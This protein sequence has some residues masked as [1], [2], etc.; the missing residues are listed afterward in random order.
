MQTALRGT[1]SIFSPGQ[2]LRRPSPG[3]TFPSPNPSGAA[4]GPSRPSRHCMAAT[5]KQG[6][7]LLDRP[8]V[9]PGMDRVNETK[10]KKPPMYRV[11]LHNDNNNRR[12]YVVKVLMK[13]V[14]GLTVDDAVHVMNEAH[15]NG[16]ACVVACAQEDAERYCE[17]LR[18]NGLIASI[19]PCSSKS[20]H[21]PGWHMMS[22]Q[23]EELSEL[24]MA[25]NPR[26][27][28]EDISNRQ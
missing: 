4:W 6:G 10:K 22:S 20:D 24:K 28:E 19:E 17:G 14:D 8:T 2:A 16:L 11:M 15:V 1:Q 26:S 7:G 21:S 5:G 3:V 13:I 9:T 18:N 12:E 23:N 27:N 25:S